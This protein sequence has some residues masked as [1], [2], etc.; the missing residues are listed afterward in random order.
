MRSMI[1][2]VGAAVWRP[3]AERSRGHASSGPLLLGTLAALL[4]GLG[5]RLLTGWSSPLWFDETFSAVIATQPWGEPLW[6]WLTH[7]LGGPVYYLL[8]WGWVQIAGAS[9]LSLRLPSLLFSVAAP[10]FVL[11]RGHPE[12]RVRLMWAGLLALYGASF[13]QA[14]EARCYSLL[15]LLTTLQVSAFM[16]LLRAP[17]TRRAALWVGLGALALLTHYHAAFIC[18]VQGLFY[19]GHA[20]M[21]AVKTW[22]ALLL[23]VPVVAWLAVALPFVIAYATSG[24]TWYSP[25]STWQLLNIWRLLLDYPVIGRW[26]FYGLVLTGLLA[27]A[28]RPVRRTFRVEPVEA[29]AALSGVGATLIVVLIASVSASFTARYLTPYV[30][31]VLLGIALWTRGLDRINPHAGMTI[32]LA[33]AA[34]AF[35]LLR[36]M[37]QNPEY[38]RRYQFEFQ[39][40]SQWIMDHGGARHVQ[41]LW[42]NPTGDF[43]SESH[44]RDAGGFFFRRAG[45][46]QVTIAR[47]PRA[48]DPF[49]ALIKAAGARPGG[50]LLW[51]YD[52]AVPGT[53]GK[54]HPARL[55][56]FPDWTCSAFGAGIARAVACVPRR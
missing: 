31:A 56:R 46:V 2:E 23:L 47:P 19:L 51:V 53:R 39:R 33:I 22:P 54:L 10:A 32:L 35:A 52:P 42:D 4:V 6:E 12:Y 20:R 48:S 7:E 9:D 8:L 29:L 15:V 14:S 3:A 37:V 34:V 1:G 49:P 5:H 11:W 13:I 21:R 30:P 45:D 43:S 16:A 41:F 26:I 38:D 27:T 25:T 55:D 36:L 50:A 18:L 44:L 17:D 24:A 40:A 28:S